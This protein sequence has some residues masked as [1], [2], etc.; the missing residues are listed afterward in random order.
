MV[1]MLFNAR[2]EEITV[3]VKA[4]KHGEKGI[5]KHLMLNETMYKYNDILHQKTIIVCEGEWDALSWERAGFLYATSVS[6]GAPNENDLNIE[7]TFLHL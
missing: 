1:G 6:Q 4:R 5:S 7:K 3:N 2:E